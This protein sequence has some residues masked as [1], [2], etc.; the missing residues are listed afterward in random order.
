[1]GA[2]LRGEHAL[3]D[4]TNQADRDRLIAAGYVD[5]GPVSL[6]DIQALVQSGTTFQDAQQRLLSMPLFFAPPAS[7]SEGR[8]IFRIANRTTGRRFQTTDEFEKNQLVQTGVWTDEGIAYRGGVFPT[9]PGTRL[10]RVFQLL[11]PNGGGIFLT[12]H[13]SE[14]ATA[15]AAD[16]LDA[17]SGVDPESFER[18]G[19]YID[20]QDGDGRPIPLGDEVSLD[21]LPGLVPIHRMFKRVP[22]FRLHIR[23]TFLASGGNLQ[24]K[25][26]TQIQRVRELFARLGMSFE[27]ASDERG[28]RRVRGVRWRTADPGSTDGGSGGALFA[29][30]RGSAG[31]DGGVFRSQHDPAAGRVRRIADRQTIA[32]RNRGQRRI[33]AGP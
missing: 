31:R 5:D 24:P 12:V 16:F 1:M 27:V 3:V 17:D 13:D 10:R 25:F 32:D 7:A 11:H 2:I 21:P 9:T 19:G 26:D 20:V 30:P 18:G 23:V 33:H 14:R 29:S 15:L 22:T 4:G 6:A 8:P 28:G